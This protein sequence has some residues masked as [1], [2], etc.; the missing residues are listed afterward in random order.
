MP[1]LLMT[2]IPAH[3][4]LAANPLM[5]VWQGVWPYLLML[6][7]FSL[8]IFVHELG[9]FAVAK[10]AGIRVQRFAI[11]FG[12]EIVG[13]TRGETRYS[14][15]IL[16]LGGYVKML[17]QEDFDDKAD[18][19]RFNDDPRSFVNKPVSHRMAVVSAGVIM[20]VLFACLLFMFVFM[21]GMKA[22]GTRVGFVEPDSPADK[23][24]L[25]PGDDIK[26]I[27]DEK[28]LE[29]RDISMAIMLAPPHEPIRFDV[30]RRGKRIEPLYVKPDYRRPDNTR[31][32]RRQV[33]GIM[34]G[35]TREIVWVGPGLRSAKANEPK[36]GDVIVE[37]DGVAVTDQNA[38]QVR[39]TLAYASEIYVERKD[40]NHPDAE[41]KRV[42]VDVPPQLALYPSDPKNK[43]S[44]SVLG[45]TPLVRFGIVN[46]TG[47]AYLA[48]IGI[49]DTILWWDD[50]PH[51]AKA[52]IDRS[53]RDNAERDIPFKV[54]KPNGKVLEG[55]VRPKRVRL[56]GATLQ[57]VVASIQSGDTARDRPRARFAD[58]RSGQRAALAGIES[59]DLI[60]TCNKVNH[61]SRA[62]VRAFIRAN[63]GKPV[64]FTV[65][66]TDGSILRTV[67]YPD[68]PGSLDASYSLVADDVLQIGDIDPV[69]NGRPSPA[70]EAGIPPGVRI[71]EVNGEAV[72]NWRGLI[73]AF[74]A[75]AGTSV[76]L[77]YIASNGA[78][79]VAAFSVPSS[80]RT[81][82]GV[83]PE[84]RIISI[85]GHESAKVH[86]GRGPGGFEKVHVGYHEGTRTLL[87]ELV[88][89]SDVPVVYRPTPLAPRQTT[90]IAV[91]ADMV[92]PWVG[93]VA[94]APNMDVGPELIILKGENM[95]DAIRIGIHKTY[96]FVR[97]VY[98]TMNRM[99][100][101]RS[102]GVE[103]ISGPLGIVS[104]GGQIARAGMVE[105]LFFLAI[106][107]AN[108]AVI[109]FLP[110]PIVDGGL[111]VFLIVEKI[112]GSPVS[113]RVQVAT[114]MVGIFLIIGMFLFVTYQ[115][116]LRLVG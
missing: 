30:E 109:N 55:F 94:F 19:L 11:G 5:A 18:E 95:L 6:L 112:K 43:R 60:L 75:N 50:Q 48:G 67:V 23:A 35:Y 99:I 44:I 3:S 31:D 84:A 59:G 86:T 49:G 98:E 36:V 93:R 57:A 71:S 72:T 17:G 24:G 106:I 68:A 61:P 110:L 37:V 46:P 21:I 2:M 108:L 83:G 97:Q 103:A 42:R 88:G 51:P 105:F 78:R 115:D 15:N 29:F 22:I 73:D 85:D 41:A 87:T 13:F 116:I 56:G 102:V 92:D 66:K 89:R 96:V 52:D 26:R 114:Q 101:S 70:A 12:K 64:T 32:A 25:L 54:R 82:L 80:L 100:F 39:N 7:G 53:V 33:I 40:P 77:G 38:N 1:G 9:H 47:R 111:M 16:P 113:L 81:L 65:R 90:R 58:V 79:K 76:E 74:R 63:A 69:I 34:P 28:I 107:S 27:N 8:I 45:L 20:N 14:F 10:W 91:T 4:F 62:A 104:V